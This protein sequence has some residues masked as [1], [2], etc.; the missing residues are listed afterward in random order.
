[1]KKILILFLLLVN[2]HVITDHGALSV[3]FGTISA[4]TM[5]EEQLG[6]VVVIGSL[7]VDCDWCRG[8]FARADLEY[9]KQ[10]DCPERMIECETCRVSYKAYLGHNCHGVGGSSGNGGSSGGSG[11]GGSSGGSG[12]GGN[13]GSN[14][15]G[16][17][18]Q[19]SNDPPKDSS[20]NYSVSYLRYKGVKLV[21]YN[22]PDRLHPQEREQECVARAYAF[23]AEMSGHDYNTVF[24][25]LD[26]I[27]KLKDRN[28]KFEGVY[29]N[30][31]T[32]FF[33]EYCNIVKRVYEPA[34]IESYIDKGVPVAVVDIVSTEADKE[35]NKH[36]VTIIGYDNNFY[37]TA[38]GNKKGH[39]TVYPKGEFYEYGY[40]YSLEKIKTP[41]K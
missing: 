13:G 33:E 22:L 17:T 35:P 11:G 28:F 32:T 38:A 20:R 3:G 8:S 2:L 5:L 6:E 34:T 4:Q 30:E 16:N 27:A 12:S 37:Y 40:F 25:A 21:S 24:K 9:H 10:Y 23:I 36:M 19:N 29:P 7:Y 31:M 15:S 14:S 1:M 26:D 39:A 41:N 18:G